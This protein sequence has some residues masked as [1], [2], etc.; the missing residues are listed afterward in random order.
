MTPLQLAA[1]Q[2]G[3]SLKVLELLISAEANVN[4]ARENGKKPIDDAGKNG[5]MLLAAAEGTRAPTRNSHSG[6]LGALLTGA[7]VG[8]IAAASGV[9]ADAAAE[10]S[11]ATAEEVLNDQQANQVPSQPAG[12]SNGSS[13]PTG[14]AL[15]GSGACLIPGWPNLSDEEIG[16]VSFSTCPA[17]ITFQVRSFVGAAAS[18]QCAIAK[19]TSSTPA[20]IRARRMDIRGYCERAEMVSATL[21][22]NG[23]T[24]TCP[25]EL[26]RD[27]Q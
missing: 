22:R 19:G 17:N 1:W 11:L 27:G 8:G 14:S 15:T 23:A 2:E 13:F 5:K 12:S 21:L 25:P 6:G 24:C 18:A 9:E 20:Q 4:T 26:L 10:A 3:S 7:A 16:S